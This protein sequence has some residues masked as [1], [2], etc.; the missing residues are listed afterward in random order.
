M[1]VRKRNGG[2]GD[3]D[4]GRD[5]TEIETGLHSERSRIKGDE[6]NIALLFFL[7]LLQGVPLGLMQA[8]PIIL[9][10]IGVS[11]AQ[12]ATLSL[13]NWPFSMKLLWAPIV[14]SVYFKKIGR[15]K[16]WLIPSQYL[17]GIVMLLL[18]GCVNSLLEVDGDVKEPNILVLTIAFFLLN[19]LA[20]T[21]DIAVDGW[22]LTMLKRQNVSYASTCNSVGQTA[23]YFLGYVV[24]VA[25]ESA[26]FC[27]TYIRSE[28]KP[29]GIFTLSDFLYFWGWVFIVVTSLIFG[30]KSEKPVSSSQ[31]TLSVADSY[32]LLLKIVVLKPMKLLAA[33]LLSSKVAFAACDVVTGLKL[34]EAGVPREK[35]ALLAVPMVPLQ[36]LLPL[37]LTRHI[38]GP[39]TMQMYLKAYPYRLVFG[40]LFAVLVWTTP[41]F[42][43]NEGIPTYY[44]VIFI[45][46]YCFH[47]VTA[48]SMYVSQ[49]AFFAKVS[50]PAV[51]GTYMTL[52]NTLANAGGTWPQSLSLWLVDHLSVKQ[53]STDALNNCANSVKLKACESTNG[54]C[55]TK[56]DGYYAEVV[57]CTVVGCLW[58]IWG[59]KAIKKLDSF[60]VKSYSIEK[61]VGVR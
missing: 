49:M 45:I 6:K 28:P 30:L 37:Y 33:V 35:M 14:D 41:S 1:S 12:Q 52:M 19:F 29:H 9:T 40:I 23:G 60:S 57:L 51:G 46:I 27:N 54:I 15:R 59:R 38:S 21:Q 8:F 2:A 50:D 20:A 55:V 13:A 36:V 18:S 53:C 43:K 58:L 48:N 16:S 39:N 10:N 11:Y 44:Y 34:I 4:S 56:I 26:S 17:I 7:Y 3:V 42:I 61:N 32:K 24:F 25:L 22:A 5:F 31:T 47:Q